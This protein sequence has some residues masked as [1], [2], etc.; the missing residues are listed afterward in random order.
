MP[1]LEF[2]FAS[3]TEESV[4]YRKFSQTTVV[5]CDVRMC[6]MH[7]SYLNFRKVKTIMTTEN[8]TN[9]SNQE[10]LIL[11]DIFLLLCL[12]PDTAF[13][14]L[15]PANSVSKTSQKGVSKHGH[16]HKIAVFV[17]D[18]CFVKETNTDTNPFFRR[19]S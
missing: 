2:V 18:F 9:V 4:S 15:C 7:V 6:Q 5:L 11:L 17:S 10:E 14:H 12:C 19:N 8:D 1:N 13:L 16:K 3:D